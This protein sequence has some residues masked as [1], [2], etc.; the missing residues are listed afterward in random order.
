MLQIEML[1]AKHGDALL[2]QYGDANETHRI[3]IDGGVWHAYN[4][5]GG[6]FERLSQLGDD[7]KEF[8]LLVI[9]HIDTDH[10]DGVIK[11]LQENTLGLT[12]KDVWFNGWKHV[13]LAVEGQLGG[14]QGEFLGA[15]LERDNLPWNINPAWEPSMGAVVVPRSG[16]L[17]VAQLAGGAKAT[18]V[19]PG[20]EQLRALEKKW[21]DT[22]K[23]A[24]FKAGD[25]RA[26]ILKKLEE[27]SDLQAEVDEGKLGATVDTS[28]ANASSIAFVFE[29]ED[30]RLLLTGDAFA[31]VLETNIRQY[32]QQHGPLHVHAFKLPH[33]GSWSN[34]SG[35][36]VRMIDA[37]AYLVSTNG[38]QHDHPDEDAIEL[39][40]RHGTVNPHFVFNYD[41]EH[42]RP[43]L[44][45]DNQKDR[46]YTAERSN[47][48]VIES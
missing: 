14:K 17:P 12:F 1:N 13:E 24:G 41:Q 19:S 43:W 23:G 22:L 39:L 27:R 48:Y 8:E 35:D 11:I 31:T 3:L 42:T 4:K 7:E 9:T 6:L 45:K 2:L 29:F 46:E 32:E 25:D 36:L 20:V 15:L 18:L 26:T 33:H 21:K 5:P 44:D 28:E 16:E 40:L 37:D 47:V 30:K 38:A 34:L 10:I